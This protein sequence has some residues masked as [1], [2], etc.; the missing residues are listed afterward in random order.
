VSPQRVVD[1][2]HARV[3]VLARELASLYRRDGRDHLVVDAATVENADRW[4][5]AAR[6]AGRLLGIHVRTGLNESTLW[7]VGID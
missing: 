1:L 2:E 7:M 4:R 6:R 3:E 5:A